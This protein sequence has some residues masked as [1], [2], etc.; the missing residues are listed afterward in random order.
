MSNKFC[1]LLS[2]GYKINVDKGELLWSPCCFYSEKTPLLDRT[3]FQQ[4]IARTSQAESWLPECSWCQQMEESGVPG[5][6]PRLNSFSKFP[7]MP[8]EQC[9]FLEISFDIKCNAACLSCGNYCS[10]TWQKYETKHRL[11][12]FKP[13]TAD[14]SDRLFQQLVNTVD[15][16]TVRD[17]FVMGGEPLYSETNLKF[18]SYLHQHHPRLDQVTIS[19]QTNGSV[20]PSPEVKEL[21]RAF[22]SVRF[23]LSIDGTGARFE[24]LRWPLKWYRV[25]RTIEDLLATTDAQFTINATVSPLNLMYFGEIEQWSDGCVPADRLYNRHG[26]YAVRPNRATRPLDLALTPPEYRRRAVEHYGADHKISLVLSNLEQADHYTAMFDYIEKHDA[27]RRLDWRETFPAVAD[28][29]REYFY[30]EYLKNPQ[31]HAI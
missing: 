10:T 2:N 13:Y 24:Y 21:L 22:G 9:G 18:L 11:N 26:A 29:Y 31:A 5:L 23:N 12:S 15:I 17:I 1:R 3:A 30:Q 8:N 4:A 28:Y 27:I 20:I 7:D 16:T 14:E 19:Y 25:E 6:A